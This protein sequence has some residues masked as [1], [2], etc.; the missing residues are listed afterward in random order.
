MVHGGNSAEMD[1][2]GTGGGV[3]NQR[4]GLIGSGFPAN[5][6]VCKI[7]A[8]IVFEFVPTSSA[9][10]LSVMDFPSSGVLTSQFESAMFARLPVLQCLTM[11]DANRIA[12]ALP[13]R[14]IAYDDLMKLLETAVTGI[15]PAGNM[16]G[17]AHGGMEGMGLA[18]PNMS[19]DA[20]IE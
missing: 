12:T 11:D 20:V 19:F 18:L 10:P 15:T 13:N 5:T 2:Y 7:I 17:L 16:F 3:P 6:S 14:P 9:F 4:F 8:T 1:L